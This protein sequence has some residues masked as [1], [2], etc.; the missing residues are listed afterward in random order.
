MFPRVGV[1]HI[2]AG[3]PREHRKAPVLR[4]HQGNGTALILDELRRRQVS[5]AAKACRVNDL[6]DAPFDRLRHGHL[7]D[8]RPSVPPRNL[9][10]ER[11]K[12]V[13]VR[14]HGGAVDGRH[15]RGQR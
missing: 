5:R 1:N 12:L 9:C 8:R 7:L 14:H 3:G 4:G 2:R 10:A 15:A 11:E 13:S 6:R